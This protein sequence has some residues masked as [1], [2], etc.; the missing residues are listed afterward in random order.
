MSRSNSPLFGSLRFRLCLVSCLFLFTIA[1]YSQFQVAERSKSKPSVPE[2]FAISDTKKSCCSR[3]ANKTTFAS[4]DYPDYETYTLT[5]TYYSL[6]ENLTAT[7]MLNNKAPEP[8]LAT[9]TF[10]SLNG[11]RLRLPPITV[12]AASYID[13]EL[14]ELLA[15]AD[16]EFREGSMKIAYQGIYYQLGCQIKLI[17]AQKSLIWAEQFVYTSKFVSNRLESVWWLPTD[18]AETKFV[19]SNTTSSPISVTINVDGTTPQQSSPKVIQL[20]PWETKVLDIMRDVVGHPYGSLQTKGGISVAHNGTP[21]AVLAKIYVSKANRGYSST[22]SFVDPDA[23]ASQR[24]HGNGLRLR[25]LD[26]QQLRP[27]LVARNTNDQATTIRGKIPYT[28]PDGEV[29]SVIIPDTQIAANSTKLI[30][31]H[32]LLTSAGITATVG[33]TGIEL[34]YD[35]PKGSVVTSVVSVSQNNNHVFQVPMFDPQKTPTSAGGYPWKADGDYSTILYIKNETDQPKKYTVFLSYEGGG[36]T[37]GVKE[38]KGSE[39]IAIDFRALRDAGASDV[40]GTVIPLNLTKGQI[41]WSVSGVDNKTLSGRSEQISVSGGTSSTYDCRNCC[42]NSIYDGWLTSFS[43]FDVVG[44]VT[45]FI[46]M[47]Q[48]KNCMG[49]TY[50]PYPADFVNWDSTNWGVA[51]IDY[52]GQSTAVGVGSANI[53]GSWEGV[54]WWDWGMELCDPVYVP[55]D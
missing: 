45:G 1:G 55:I 30:N 16:E 31:L 48:D 47:Q 44:D 5:G 28:R 20:N 37:L 35:S 15:D 14:R 41:A 36:Y 34:E 27:I 46:A 43:T 11:T 22:V 50:P 51:S 6:E 4:L 53:Q 33:Y 8:V 38:L 2:I 21:G 10:Y 32:G 25:N 24:L 17:D 26:G 29:A 9:P 39:T 49:Q 3:S 54:T 23:T 12:P 19:V 40:N 13:V 52:N 42:P 7:L 18:D